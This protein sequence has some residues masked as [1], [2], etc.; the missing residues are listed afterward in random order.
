MRSKILREY[1]KLNYRKNKIRATYVI[2]T[3]K[4]RRIGLLKDKEH[5]YSNFYIKYYFKLSSRLKFISA[6]VVRN[7]NKKKT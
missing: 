5:T 7:K 2:V 4:I 1:E 6:I 3:I